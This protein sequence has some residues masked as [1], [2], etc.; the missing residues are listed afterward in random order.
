PVRAGARARRNN[1]ARDALVCMR[2]CRGFAKSSIGLVAGLA[3]AI[4]CGPIPFVAAGAAPIQTSQKH[5]SLKQGSPKQ[6]ALKHGSPKQES[7]KQESRKQES[8]KQEQP[9]R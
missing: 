9:S 4:L 5:P 6:G 8:R 3:G 1:P 7:L 2:T